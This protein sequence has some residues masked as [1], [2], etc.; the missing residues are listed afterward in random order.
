MKQL[1]LLLVVLGV[2][3]MARA[4]GYLVAD[5]ITFNGINGGIGFTTRVL[6][7]PTSGDYGVVFLNPVGGNSFLFATTADQGIRTF[8]VSANDPISL[9]SITASSYPELAYPNTYSFP[10]GSTFFLGFFTGSTMPENGIYADPLF[11]WGQFRNVN[12]AITFLGGALEYGGGGIYAGTQTIIPVPEPTVL[13][14]AGLGLA[15]VLGRTRK[16]KPGCET[17]EN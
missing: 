4:Q 9:Q 17:W 7:S 6:Q 2:C 1:V 5:G 12:G 13:G 11:G 8:L 15:F 14:L 16:A 10:N 3:P